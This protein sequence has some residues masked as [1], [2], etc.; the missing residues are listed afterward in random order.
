[1]KRVSIYI[2][3]FFLAI[4]VFGLSANNSVAGGNGIGDRLVMVTY[5]GE[6][7]VA[8]IDIEGKEGAE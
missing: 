1:M 3:V 8:L 7:K 5:W 2:S 4:S 6:D